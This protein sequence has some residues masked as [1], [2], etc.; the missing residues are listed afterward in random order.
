[1]FDV[2]FTLRALDTAV[3]GGPIVQVVDVSDGL[4]SVDL[5]FGGGVFEGG[6]RLL[7]IKVRPDGSMGAY[8]ELLPW[9]EIHAAPQSQYSLSTRGI[10]VSSDKDVG[11]GT[12]T[13]ASKFT[14]YQNGGRGG[15]YFE[16]DNSEN[17]EAAISGRTN[18]IGSAGV[19]V[20]SNPTNTEP[21]VMGSALSS[22]N[23]GLFQILNSMNTQAAVR[24]L[25]T[26]V[27]HAGY[28]GIMNPKNF[29]SSIFAI[30]DGQG[31]AAEFES[32]GSASTL[33]AKNF[34]FG[35]VGEF[36]SVGAFSG[37]PAVLART[38]GLG[39]AGQF[40]VMNPGND[41]PVLYAGGN[42]T[43]PAALI[44]GDLHVSDDIK[45]DFGGIF[46]RT[47]PIAYA[48]VSTG[49]VVLSG[50]PNISV[51]SVSFPVGYDIAVSGEML[52]TSDYTTLVVPTG[53]GS[54]PVVPSI[55]SVGGG[56]L[57]VTLTALN[58]DVFNAPDFGPA[59]GAFQI[60]IFKG[61]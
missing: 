24:G 20:N 33:Y 5:E 4:F 37:S 57:R 59:A 35:A 3:I 22:G 55:L 49:G 17:E 21:V 23:A 30:T 61:D 13:L 54:V 34:G 51:A 39:I 12:Q 26:G 36:H 10:F 40:Q 48:T 16:I 18:G 27:G 53:G 46:A 25:T 41:A 52:N 15:G 1:M 31:H 9:V 58:H 38:D 45:Q 50:T 44:D 2:E 43:G 14:V 29:A 8:T 47:T 28:F 19:F 42:G 7:Q 60:V 32:T 11:I 6:M 56:M